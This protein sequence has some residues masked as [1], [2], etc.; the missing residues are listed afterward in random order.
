MRPGDLVKTD[1]GRVSLHRDRSWSDPGSTTD[2]NDGNPVIA[3]MDAD[4]YGMVLATA[5][6]E[7]TDSHHDR[8]EEWCLILYGLRLGWRETRFFQVIS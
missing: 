8:S 3:V 7:A 6:H 2:I 1:A 4:R 5:Y